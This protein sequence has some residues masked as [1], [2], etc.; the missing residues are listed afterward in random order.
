MKIEELIE[1]VALKLLKLASIKL[2]Q[3]V[4]DSLIKAYNKERSAIAKIQ[5]KNMIDNLK[6]AEEKNIPICQDTGLI[7]FYLEVGPNFKSLNKIKNALTRTVRRATKEIPLRPNAVDPFTHINTDDNTGKNV[8]Y[9]NWKITDEDHLKIT[10][11]PKGAGSENYSVLRMLTPSE[12]EIGLK[13]FIIETVLK[14]GGFPCPPT[15]IGIGIGGGGNI[16]M[17]LAKKALLRPIN[18]I[19]TNEKTAQLER[20]LFEDIN[21]TGIGPMGLGGDTTTLSVNIEYA[22]RHPA[23]F[24]VAIVFNCWA[25][26][27]ASARINS[28]G[29]IEYLTHKI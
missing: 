5:L 12:G 9:F 1:N 19:N 16:A 13:K 25:A 2:P 8:P 10:V 4:K 23:S 18:E 27:R 7:H 14:A 15:I 28:Y 29:D 24:P 26:R 11:L 3:D 21:N 17:E 22:H 6:K 20:E